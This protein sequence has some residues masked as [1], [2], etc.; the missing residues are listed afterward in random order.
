MCRTRAVVFVLL[1]PF[2]PSGFCDEPPPA[3]AAAL[4]AFK[5]ALEKGDLKAVAESAAGESGNILRRLA[6]PIAKAKAASDRLDKALTEK[7]EIGWQNPFAPGVAPLTGQLEI[8]EIAKEGDSVVARVRYGQADQEESLG[9]RNEGGAWRVDLPAELARALRPLANPER[10]E[11]RRKEL[12]QLAEVLNS[13]A[14]DI[15]TGKRKT[16]E[17]VILRLIEL[18]SESNLV[19]APSESKPSGKP[20]GSDR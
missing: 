16:K 15:E 1:V 12:E 19:S 3:Q 5:T 18:A 14:A 7:P 20:N 11:R 17:E 6:D 2:V 13:L 4:Q 10:L 9:I 8:V